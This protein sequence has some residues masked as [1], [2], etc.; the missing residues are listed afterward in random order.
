MY[1][2]VFRSPWTPGLSFV[3]RSF[4]ARPTRPT[5][6]WPRFVLGPTIAVCR[7]MESRRPIRH[8]PQPAPP[9]RARCIRAAGPPGA[10]GGVDFVRYT[11]GT[12]STGSLLFVAHEGGEMRRLL[13]TRCCGGS[14]PTSRSAWKSRKPGSRISPSKGHDM[15]RNTPDTGCVGCFFRRVS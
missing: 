1:P 14:R 6:S 4:P 10:V 15:N 2:C 9:R 12:V 8:G 13:P 7:S 3:F 5:A 11:V